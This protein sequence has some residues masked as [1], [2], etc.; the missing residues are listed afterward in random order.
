MSDATVRVTIERYD[1]EKKERYLQTYEVPR[2]SKSRVLDFLE[3]IFEELDPSLAY[4]RHLC[5]ARMCHGCLMMV[6]GKPSMVC[7]E[8]VSAQQTEITLSPLKG[9]TV[10]KDLVAEFGGLEPEEPGQS[11]LP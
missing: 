3:Y 1:P 8:V 7:W 2:G 11:S 6:N 9:R 5:K 4:R 10:F